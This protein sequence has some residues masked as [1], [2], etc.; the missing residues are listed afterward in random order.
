[1]LILLCVAMCQQLAAQATVNPTELMRKA[2]TATERIEAYKT[3]FRFYEYSHPDSAKI[4]LQKGMNEFTETRNQI[5]IGSMTILDAYMDADQGRRAKAKEKYIRALEIFTKENYL[6]GIANAHSGIGIQE[7]KSGNFTVAT[8]HFLKALQIFESTGNRDGVVNI[9]QKLGAVN[10]TSNNLTKALEYYF[11]A[12]KEITKSPVKGTNEAWI[13]NNIGIVYGKMEKLDTALYYFQIALDSCKTPA[14]TNLRLLT[15]NNLGILHGK[16]GEDAKALAYFD[17]AISITVNKELPEN[18]AHLSF[19][20]A[21]V[22]NK[23]DPLEGL[24][25]L[26]GSLLQVQKLGLRMMEIDIYETIIDAY[27]RLKQYDSSYE[28]LKKVR[29][30]EDSLNTS[31]KSQEMAE[32]ESQYEIEKA[33]IKYAQIEAKLKNDKLVTE[34]TISLAVIL[35]VLLLIVASGY[36]RKKKLNLALQQQEEQLRKS[37][38]IKDRLFSV[39]GHDLRGPLRQI[40]PSLELLEL[41]IMTKEETKYLLSSLTAQTRASIDTL[42]KLLVWGTKQMQGNQKNETRVH[43]KEQAAETLELLTASAKAKRIQLKDNLPNGT[44]MMTDPSHFDFIL[45]NLLSNAIK[46]THTDGT[47]ELNADTETQ[48]GFVVFSVTDTGI[49]IPHEEMERLFEPF[50]SASRGTA[51]EKGSGIGLMLCKE[52]TELNGGKI[53]ATSKEGEGSSFY[54]S[55]KSCTEV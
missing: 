30:L 34:L 45:R 3:I 16:M 42:D 21:S 13:F 6:N 10:E 25:L 53:W 44:C 37:N 49:G 51:N 32:L 12:I 23:T 9:Y 17:E 8:K 47:V 38:E 24:K 26:K 48:P 5:G 2:K 7:V 18:Q 14:F 50:N 31:V 11:L 46:F 40:P 4:Y 41:N 39:I 55:L 19:N 54:F 20:R 33:R 35:A 52:Y 28:Y 43:V 29:S 36:M 1:M 22:V 15:L 27:D